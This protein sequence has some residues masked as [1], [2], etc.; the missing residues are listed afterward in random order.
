MHLSRPTALLVVLALVA[1]E[2]P[3]GPDARY[4]GYLRLGDIQGP[5]VEVMQD[6]DSLAVVVRTYGLDGCYVAAGE[7]ADV[8]GRTLT[9]RPFDRIVREDG[10]V[11]PGEIVSLHHDVAI[12]AAAVGMWTVRI[13]GSRYEGG[14]V[15]PDSVITQFE[16]VGQLVPF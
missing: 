11:C 4:P 2:D 10:V 7:H 13:L 5:D 1:C 3:S 15:E 6:G 12:D 14:T 8:E 9:L 16:I